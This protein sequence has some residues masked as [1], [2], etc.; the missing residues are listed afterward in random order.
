MIGRIF[1]GIMAA[2]LAAFMVACLF[3]LILATVWA[4]AGI[5]FVFATM[6]ELYHD[7]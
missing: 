5:L 2:I 7:A 6:F 1:W 4:G 3:G